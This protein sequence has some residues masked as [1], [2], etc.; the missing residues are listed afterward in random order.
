MLQ[1]TGVSMIMY[2]KLVY[3]SCAYEMTDDIFFIDTHMF[4][5]VHIIFTYILHNCSYATTHYTT[6]SFLTCSCE[7]ELHPLD[8]YFAN[9]MPL[10]WQALWSVRILGLQFATQ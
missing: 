5:L 4:I 9:R 7:C 2:A 1:A 8:V 10:R 6:F 3:W